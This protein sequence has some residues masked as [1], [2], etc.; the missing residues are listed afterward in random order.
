MK[1]VSYSGLSLYQKCPSAFYRRYIAN[2]D[3]IKGESSPA[4]MRGSALHKAVEEFLLGA[5]EL[6]DELEFYEEFFT[7]LR[8]NQTLRPEAKWQFSH[9]WEE[10][11]FGSQDG[12]IRGIMDAAL[13]NGDSAYVYEFKTGKVYAEHMLQRALYGLA[14]LLLFPMAKECT[15]FTMYLDHHQHEVST[16]EASSIK[17]YQWMWKQ[18]AE[19]VWGNEHYPEKPSWKCKYCPYSQSRGGTCPN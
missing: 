3:V 13:Q 17:A 8:E 11:P 5:D 1:P 19:E 10:L 15:V 16:Y 4:A 6:P 12:M 14:G 2:E 18:R 7:N 9:E